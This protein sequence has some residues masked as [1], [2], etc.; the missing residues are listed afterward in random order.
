MVDE[1]DKDLFVQYLKDPFRSSVL[2]D[3][4][5]ARKDTWSRTFG[6]LRCSKFSDKDF[7]KKILEHFHRTDQSCW[8]DFES[9]FNK[10]WIK[11]CKI[12][13]DFL[14][15]KSLDPK[16][17]KLLPSNFTTLP[18]LTFIDS[19]KERFSPTERVTLSVDLKNVPSLFIKVFEFQ[20][21]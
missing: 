20:L 12:T 21:A 4:K 7:F 1:Y 3:S 10:D 11:E 18:L 9:Y 5:K 14:S 13:L 15:G 19:N 16:D 6:A 17:L 2:K 8:K